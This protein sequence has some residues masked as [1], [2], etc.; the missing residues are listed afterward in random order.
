MTN[1]GAGEWRKGW[2]VVLA[3][4]CCMWLSSVTFNSVGIFMRPL[5]DAFGWS[6]ADL[7]G[8]VTI[9]ALAMALASPWVGKLADRWGPRRIGLVGCVIVC[10][11]FGCLS[12]IQS[13]V[14]SYLGM[15]LAIAIGSALASPVIWTMGVASRF[16]ERRGLALA[17]A[18]CGT[19]LAGV[20][21]PPLGTALIGAIGWRRAYVSL[22]LILFLIAFPIAFALFRDARDVAAPPRAKDGGPDIAGREGPPQQLSGLSLAEALRTARLWLMAIALFMGSGSLLAL[23]VHLAPLL[24]DRG[25]TAMQAA[26]GVSCLALAALGGKLSAGYLSDR[27][28]ARLIAAAVLALPA[29]AIVMLRESHDLASALIASAL[30]GVG[31]GAQ[32]QLVPYL[33]TRYF[34]IRSYGGIYGLLFAIFQFGSAVSPMLTGMV[35]DRMGSYQPVLDVLAPACLVSGVLMLFLGPYP[36]FGAETRNERLA[37]TVS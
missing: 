37:A 20:V 8:A 4:F 16:R 24:I 21:T 23:L 32:L 17:L 31:S 9:S 3:A 35:Y 2:G 13:S 7:A 11:L 5:T 26:S 30:V 34:G 25:F 27:V 28:P 15:W 1:A 6:R 33:T 36:V 18:L 12:L 29:V 10:V 22:A 19:S 14:Y